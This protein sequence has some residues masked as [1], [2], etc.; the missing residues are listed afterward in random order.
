MLPAPVCLSLQMKKGP[1]RK[2][3]KITREAPVHGPLC[4][5][6]SVLNGSPGPILSC[7][8]F[9]NSRSVISYIPEEYSALRL[10][11]RERQTSTK[12]TQVSI[13]VRRKH[14]LLPD[15]RG[16]LEETCFQVTGWFPHGIMLY[17]PNLLAGWKF[18]GSGSLVL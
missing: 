17:Y 6:S 7:V 2:G 3:F 13:T 15:P 9:Q 8:V 1:S 11:W 16:P 18:K 14:W 10:S 12:R 5:S 4:A